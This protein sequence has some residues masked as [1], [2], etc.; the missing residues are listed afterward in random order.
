VVKKGWFFVLRRLVLMMVGAKRFAKYLASIL[1]FAVVFANTYSTAS[2]QTN[3]T[4]RPSVQVIN[5]GT[6]TIIAAALESSGYRGQALVLEQLR[7]MLDKMALLIF[8]GVF[9]S[10]LM[11]VAML[12]KY[13]AASWVLVGP[14]LFF[15]LTKTTTLATGV[16]WQNAG[17][18]VEEA[19]GTGDSD[20]PK[21]SWVFH[22]Y[23]R[24][25]SNFI[26]NMIRIV[27]DDGIR[28][29]TRK[30]TSRQRIMED[31]LAD[32]IKNPELLGFT[33]FSL[34]QCSEQLS[35]ARTIARGRNNARFRNTPEYLAADAEYKRSYAVKNISLDQA[36]GAY[37]RDLL[38]TYGT[39]TSASTAG[40]TPAQAA[41]EP[42]LLTQCINQQVTG[43]GMSMPVS[44]G[45]ISSLTSNPVS[46][47]D[48]WCWMG[49]GVQRQVIDTLK[50]STENTV[51]KEDPD[52]VPS[53]AD[54]DVYK[55]IWDELALKL[56]KPEVL[57]DQYGN[58]VERAEADLS[59]IPTVIGGY[60]IRK[61][62][63][64][65]PRSNAIS[66]IA[67]KSG[68]QV[69]P[70]NFNF[71]ISQDQ[72][73]EMQR[74]YN[75]HTQ[76]EGQKYEVFII[77]MML[78]Y[79][80][81]LFL[82]G[83]GIM[84]PFFALMVVVPGKAA[85]FFSWMT[86]WL[87]IKSWDLGWAFVMVIDDVLWN[88]MPHDSFY[89][90]VLDPNGVAQGPIDVMESAFSGDPAYT[91]SG[92]YVLIG[93]LITGVPVI[94]AQMIL[95]G[96]Q[97]IGG[98]LVDGVK[99]MGKNLGKPAADFAAHQS[100]ANI[101][102]MRD[103]SMINGV[104]DKLRS[105][106]ASS[107]IPGLKEQSQMLSDWK[108]YGDMAK[109]AGLVTLGGA[110]AVALAPAV[111]LISIGGAVMGA[112]ALA[113]GGLGLYGAGVS[114]NRGVSKRTTELRS[115]NYEGH[116]YSF[117]DDKSFY[118]S[119][120][121]RAGVSTRN[122]WMNVP[123]VPV[124]AVASANQSL[125]NTSSEMTYLATRGAASSIKEAVS[126]LANPAL[127]AAENASSALGGN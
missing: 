21:V 59:V 76:A 28:E 78:P 7:E 71:D 114:I 64:Q 29:K 68:F 41:S 118:L 53:Q 67:G 12:G 70:F 98:M 121:L 122:E 51:G 19:E 63:T 101:N 77:S 62:M 109:T 14:V 84:F 74:R 1:V 6:G 11:T 30:F 91:L 4:T 86:L 33:A 42:P 36:S 55:E 127:G 102:W 75:Q 66:D 25:V 47:E 100:L 52:A 111:G 23:N 57:K 34:Q 35:A 38:L 22:N 17:T 46:C 13:E 93:T 99:G 10:A 117:K 26:Q 82:Y 90:P 124:D 103:A 119:D 61:M 48:L 81:G 16:E 18:K 5:T 83:L 107:A 65:D 88:L 8:I 97:A 44:A 45:N 60:L 105:G 126:M 58:P 120:Q 9:I 49:I 113:V 31:L 73:Q 15:V 96:K 94:T 50:T 54:K 27:T 116:K 32:S 108:G 115:L 92:Y 125:I 123:D 110:A 112:G 43:R 37:V 72:V 24:L 89:N 106:E 79:V 2:A 80:Q 56:A 85:E 69:A 39:S 87:W 104:T 20:A 40:V 95:G 3:P